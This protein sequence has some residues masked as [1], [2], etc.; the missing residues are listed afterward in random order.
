MF[1][2]LKNAKELGIDTSR[3][4]VV[5]D[6]YGDDD[7]SNGD[8]VELFKDDGTASP[9]FKNITTGSDE[10]FSLYWRRL[11]YKKDE[12]QIGIKL[13]EKNADDLLKYGSYLINDSGASKILV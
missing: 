12:K 13:T 2:S 6:A 9:F 7:V 3:Q 4:F 11:E 5:I 10:E 1:K 8:I